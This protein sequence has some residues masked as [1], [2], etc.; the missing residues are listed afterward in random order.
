MLFVKIPAGSDL[1]VTSFCT[2]PVWNG[3]LDDSEDTQLPFPLLWLPSV[4]TLIG[5]ETLMY[6]T[7][8]TLKP[9]DLDNSVIVY[10]FIYSL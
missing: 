1:T 6:L 2:F 5:D 7:S 10:I 4:S 8:K 9:R 3:L